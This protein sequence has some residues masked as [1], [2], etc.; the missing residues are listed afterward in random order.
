MCSCRRARGKG[1][2]PAPGH[3]NHPACSTLGHIDPDCPCSADLQK[4]ISP[5]AAEANL[6]VCICHLPA[7]L[8]LAC[9]ELQS[10]LFLLKMSL[11][12]P[13]HGYSRWL[14]KFPQMLRRNMLSL[15]CC[16][17]RAHSALLPTPASAFSLPA[18]LGTHSPDP[19]HQHPRRT[20][21]FSLCPH[22]L[23][24]SAP[25]SCLSPAPLPCPPWSPSSAGMN[26]CCPSTRHN[27]FYRGA[28]SL[29]C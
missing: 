12:P 1:H 29:C 26:P 22:L 8:H 15:L 11:F 28:S 20:C 18:F 19:C 27:C 10:F 21:P 23:K 5:T 7:S 24:G 17:G 4:V 13:L 14:L 3:S 6:S 25:P 9:A 2:Q 16:S